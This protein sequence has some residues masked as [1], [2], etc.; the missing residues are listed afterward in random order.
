MACGALKWF[1]CVW[2]TSNAERLAIVNT[3]L[4][5]LV[6]LTMKRKALD[7]CQVGGGKDTNGIW[8]SQPDILSWL[9]SLWW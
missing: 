3:F 5:I 7:A 9:E 2:T 4:Q 6:D 8:Q 1:A